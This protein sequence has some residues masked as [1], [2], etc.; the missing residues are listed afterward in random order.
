MF[1]RFTVEAIR[2]RI[3]RVVLQILKQAAVILTRAAFGGE[4]DVPYLGEFRAVVEGCY[5]HRGDSLLRRISVLQR[6]ILPHVRGRDAVDGE[7]HHRG[8]GA[9]ERD[10]S[11]AVLL[12]VW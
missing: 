1:W 9:P 10:V 8:T 2:G 6:A 3:E 11:R 7:V 4:G 12:H 5:L